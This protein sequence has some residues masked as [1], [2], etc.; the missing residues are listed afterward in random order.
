MVVEKP[1]EMPPSTPFVDPDTATL[2][3]EQIYAEAIPLAKLVGL[4]IGLALVPLVIVYL[5]AGH[6]VF[7]ALLTAIAQF[8]LAIGSG[9]VLMYVIARAK[10]LTDD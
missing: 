5:L 6:S 9:I 8:I 2:D 1:Y 10:Q 7:G 3:T 4:F